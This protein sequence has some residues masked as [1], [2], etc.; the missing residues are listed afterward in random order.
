MLFHACIN[1]HNRLLKKNFVFRKKR[2]G[3]NQASLEMLNLSLNKARSYQILGV[4]SLF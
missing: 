2:A 3:N 1:K 4:G